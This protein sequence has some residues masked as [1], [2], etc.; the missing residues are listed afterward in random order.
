MPRPGGLVTNISL[1]ALFEDVYACVRGTKDPSSMNSIFEKT[2]E[3]SKTY[4]KPNVKFSYGTAG[5][6]TRAETL[7]SVMFRMGLLSVLRSKAKGGQVIGV[8]ITASHNP[9]HDNGV[10]LV[11]P[12]GEM[13]EESWEKYASSLANSED[14]TSELKKIALQTCTDMTAA[15]NVFI[16]RDTRPSGPGLAKA[17][18]DGIQALG[19]IYHDYGLLDWFL[20]LATYDHCDGNAILPGRNR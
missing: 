7:E 12:L 11:D 15:A 20:I 2:A 13:L 18:M 10:K 6:R 4:P 16:A 19:G 17:L 1:L 9:V 3:V 14:V 8:V 5:F